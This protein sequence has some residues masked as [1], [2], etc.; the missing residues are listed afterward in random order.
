M[1]Q[2]KSQTL[3]PGPQGLSGLGFASLVT[4]T[5]G[6][7]S[8]MSPHRR[9]PNPPRFLLP[10]GCSLAYS[11]PSLFLEQ[12]NLY[13]GQTSIHLL[14][15]PIVGTHLPWGRSAHLWQAPHCF[16]NDLVP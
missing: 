13:S 10:E 11:L 8:S 5:S 3:F 6:P 2:D 7:L 14:Y 15:V 1:H 9:F 16:L 4:T 12:A